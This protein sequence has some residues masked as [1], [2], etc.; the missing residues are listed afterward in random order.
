M[1]QKIPV[2]I[3]NAIE[4]GNAILFLGAGASYDALLNGVKTNIYANLVR[5]KLSDKFLG[6]AHKKS[7][8][9]TV[10]DYA[11][12]EASLGKVQAFIRDIFIDLSPAGFHLKIPTFRWRAIVTTNYDLVIEKAYAACPTSLQKLAPVTKDGDELEIALASQN[13]VPYLKLHGCISN[14]N[15][16]DTP[17]VLDSNEYSKF[18]SG[19]ENIVKAFS[20]WATQSPIIFCGYS[21]S[22]ENIK[23][24]LFDIGDASQSRDAYLYVDLAFDDI[25]TRYW[26]GRR[27]TPYPANFETF[28]DT[29]DG[30]IPIGNRLLGAIYLRQDLSISKWIPSHEE[31]SKEL[32]QYLTLELQHVLPIAPASEAV[33]GHNFYCGLDNSFGPIYAEL[34]V[35]REISEKILNK[36]VLDT[37]EST[38]PKL[39]FI[40][41][42]A[43]CGKSVLAKRVALDTSRILD[44]P[45]VVW[46]REGAVVRPELII[47]L[48]LLIQ[49]R[50]YVFVDDVLEHQ[51]TLA[52]LV[53]KVFQRNS[54]ITI[55]AC[56]R[57]NELNI[58]GQE[59]QKRVSCDFELHDLENNEVLR[60]LD[61]L[62]Q[63]KILGP[64]EQYSAAERKLFIEKFY[65]QQLLVALHEITFGDSFEQILVNEFEKIIPR[66]AQQLYLDICTLHQSG[67]GVRAGLLSRLSGVPIP[68]LNDLLM[69]P[70]ARVVRSNFDSRYRDVVYKSRHDEIAKMVFSLAITDQDARA[71]QLIRILSKVDLDYS[72][73]NKA[74]F[75]LVKGRM[76]SDLFERKE[77]AISVF[78]AAERANPPAAYLLHQRAILEL[79]HRTG[80]IEVASE[81]LRKAEAAIRESGYR[82]SSIQHTKANLLRRRALLST[83]AVER[84][85]YR[86][87]ARTILKPQLSRKSN[88][89]PQHLLGQVLL[90]ELKEF[91]GHIHSEGQQL[92]TQ[93]I[94]EQAIVRIAT[95]LSRLID[96][97]LKTQPS[98]GPMTLLR[99]DFLRTMGRQPQ[100]I[101]VLQRFHSQ[102]P[103][104]SS[105]SRVLGEALSSA[106]KI[107]EGIEVL[108]G[109][110]LI[111]PTDKF[112]SLSLAKML[113][114]KN[115]FENSDAILSFLRRSFSDG[116]SHY[117]AR[118]LYARCNLLYG[119]I[120]R[121]KHEFRLL[122]DV[123]LENKDRP[124]YIV[125]N[126]DGTPRRYGGP[127]ISKQA[128]Y[129]FASS[130]EL[131][132][133]VHF[134]T[135]GVQPGVW[136]SM[137]QGTVIEYNV[138]FTYRGPV[139]INIRMSQ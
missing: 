2:P 78:D 33:D 25:Q 137:S 65:D 82:D 14:Y 69:G 61:K 114:K 48:Q 128:G 16:T 134:G 11:R 23:E 12:H 90:D 73:D 21:L 130:S 77:L 4:S 76:L 41:G 35:S 75:E 18:K 58:Y 102:S 67:V 27:I 44:E 104:N 108:R 129:G 19:R 113:I 131:R 110:V 8:L 81:Y 97:H 117:E 107:D 139:A 7:P 126:T 68:V 87:D 89:Y 51:D 101:Q 46:L 29:L 124:N 112:A 30:G 47:E 96:D 20:E 54:R 115:E 95:D 45:L 9:M 24:I 64:L 91:F 83:S 39:F 49:S 133:H 125:M 13:S 31:P 93:E 38:Q 136:T 121:G 99:S 103:E 135:K 132:F 36:A 26:Q 86:A 5:D 62:S 92:P 85:R 88:L 109:A 59:M 116:D 70:L 138:A 17:I 120:T 100:A 105:V 106:D 40:K 74:F 56:A 55:I 94:R 118:L 60:L 98:D 72:S 66:D 63:H 22:D 3:Q 57:T 122:R 6:G 28:M 43:G 1:F 119:D 111:S 123:Y 32:I 34:D 53:E 71:F 15:N 52:V 84:E 10:A 127:I 50:I 42:Y 80:N 37:L 79:N